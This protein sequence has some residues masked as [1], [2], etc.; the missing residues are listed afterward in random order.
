MFSGTAAISI[1]G[2]TK[3]YGRLVA[4]D[5]LDLE[6]PRGEVFGFLGLNGAG[7]TT[8]IRI[9]LDLLRPCSGNAAVFGHDCQSDGLK[10]RSSVGYL[11]GEMGVYS[12]LTGEELL[13]FVER[14][15]GGT[16]SRKYR[17]NL[18]GRFELSDRDLSRKLREYSTG[19]KRK[20]GL[21][22]AFQS[23][24]LLLILDEPTEGLDP[25]MQEAFYELLAEV[26]H[27]GCT[28][29]MSSH[30]LPEVER[31]CDRIAVLRKGEVV[32]LSSV[33]DARKLASRRVRIAFRQ[34]VAV[35]A[36]LPQGYEMIEAKPRAW[37]VRVTGQ[38][39]SL[40]SF[41][42]SLPVA[43]LAV[44]EARLEDVLVKYY[45]DGAE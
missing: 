16:V 39:G 15:G 31:V 28:V 29:F 40:P 33:E 45:R 10:A 8:T 43:D 5:H 23:D 21:I 27:R 36:S 32:L 22:Q 17:N 34:D 18:T 9:L 11:P 35:P 2:L 4:V 42:V 3:R 30:V 41:L 7:K 13:V 12:D 44:E 14:M 6:V 38:L 20:L 26:R 1:R 19:M 24:P 25:L 37:I